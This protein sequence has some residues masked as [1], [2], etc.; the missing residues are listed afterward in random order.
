MRRVMKR[1][2]VSDVIK[3]FGKGFFLSRLGSLRCVCIF[4]SDRT[5]EELER[6]IIEFRKRNQ[7]CVVLDE[8]LYI[9]PKD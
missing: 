7:C 4:T 3:E 9:F 5:E 1:L 8:I 2:H 6:L